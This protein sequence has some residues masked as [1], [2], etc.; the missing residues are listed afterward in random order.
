MPFLSYALLLK[1]SLITLVQILSMVLRYW[2]EIVNFVKFKTLERL[3]RNS[4]AFRWKCRLLFT[5]TLKGLA[6]EMIPMGAFFFFTSS[7]L[8]VVVPWNHGQLH[9]ISAI[10]QTGF[11]SK[12][13]LFSR[14]KVNWLCKMQK[15]SL[16]N[17]N[18]SNLFKLKS[19]NIITFMFLTAAVRPKSLWYECCAQ[20]PSVT[21]WYL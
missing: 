12:S 10:A 19:K 4:S 2:G 14:H 21:T 8:I 1:Q 3:S 18:E 16:Y 7:F 15:G 5:D 20:S 6:Q 9:F 13:S 11:L 17:S